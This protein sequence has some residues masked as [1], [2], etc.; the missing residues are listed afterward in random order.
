MPFYND[1][2]LI[3]FMVLQEN[4]LLSHEKQ[5]VSKNNAESCATCSTMV[6]FKFYIILYWLSILLII[7]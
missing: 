1:F 2:I 5:F 7:L 3:D 6:G 4:K